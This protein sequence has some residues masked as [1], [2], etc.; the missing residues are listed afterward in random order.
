VKGTP[1]GGYELIELLGRGGMGTGD[2]P[3]DSD[4]ESRIER[5]GD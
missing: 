5:S 1:F 2:C 4:F 3:F